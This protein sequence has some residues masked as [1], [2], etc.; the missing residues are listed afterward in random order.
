MGRARVTVDGTAPKILD[1]WFSGTWGGYRQTNELVRDLP[2]GRH[3]VRFELLPDKHAE[4]GGHEFRILG[5][6]AAGLASPSAAAPSEPAKVNLFESGMD[7]FALYRIP[8]IVVTPKGAVLAYCE[9]RR[10]DRSDWGPID[11]VMRRSADGGTTW[12]PPQA[13]V[14]VE[15]DLPMNPVAVAQKLDKPGENTA[16]NPVAIVDRETG[17]VH[18]LY[19]LEYMR[20]FAMRSDDEGVTW[21]KPVEITPA[22]ETFRRDYDWKVLATGPG[23]GIQ[24]ER[25]PHKGRLVVPVWLS[26]GTGGHAHRPSVVA[27]IVSDDHGATWRR[28]DIAVADTP[29]VRWPNE[30]AVVQLAD[31]RVMLNARSESDA[32]RRIVVTS[33]D[34][35]TGWSAPRF[36][37]ALVEPICMGALIRAGLAKDGGRN[38]IVF[39][40]PGNVARR[41]GREAPGKPRD[42]V[43][44]TL[45]MSEDEGATWPFARRIEE[46]FSGYSDLAVAPDGTILCFYERGS[47]DGASIYKTGRLTVA[48]I[49]PEWLAAGRP[50]TKPRMNTDQ[51]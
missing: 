35:A 9:A 33:P 8:G 1:A 3:R 11:I 27:T 7:G 47:T 19:C 14:H 26:L 50:G 36:D 39:S 42:R 2:P 18:F 37:E 12:T 16:N 15:G 25:G 34:G 22:F 41:D 6:G 20:C 45:R 24:L 48:R 46:G 49:D 23:H 44:L 43:N 17:A 38:R 30:T 32:H 40:N 10:S 51:H 29:P 21:T 5:L 31:G 13:V 28:G 4:S